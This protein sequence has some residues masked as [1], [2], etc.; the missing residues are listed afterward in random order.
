MSM[1]P[2]PSR[3][4]PADTAR[5]AH[6]IFH[7]GNPYLDL[8]DALG[9]LFDDA[10]FADLYAHQGAPA[11]APSCLA[12]V[13][14]LQYVEGLS[15]RQTANAVRARIDWKYLLGLSLEDDGFDASDLS[16]FRTR[17]LAGGAETTLFTQVLERCRDQGLLK[18]ERQRTDSTHVLGAIR[19]LNRLELVGETMRATLDVLAV[20]APEWLRENAA[21]EWVE[22]Y[23]PRVEEYRLPKGQAARERLATMIGA[24]GVAL[25]AAIDAAEQTWLRTIPAVGVLRQVWEQ[26]YRREGEDLVW[27]RAGQMPPSAAVICS[28]YDPDVRYSKK[29]Q[30]TWEGYKVHLTETCAADAPILITQV[31][32]TLA[33]V[34]D[35]QMTSSIQED[36]A[37]R[38]LTPALHVVDAGYINGQGLAQSQDRGI[39]LCGPVAPD[40]S[41]QARA[42]AGFALADFG[43]DWDA[44]VATC[45]QG[46]HS[47]TWRSVTDRSGA[48][49]VQVHFRI[50]DCQACPVR[51]LCTTGA[52]RSLTFRPQPAHDARQHALARQTTAA[53]AEEYTVRAGIESTFVQGN[54]RS[55]L[56]HARYRGLPKVRL[57]HRLTAAA[58]NLARV[59]AWLHAAPR[60]PT[61]RST[62]VRLMEPAA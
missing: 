57:Q 11:L 10:T 6:K 36:L 52:R 46:K 1:R 48:A 15:D 33:T 25:L 32:T 34:T 31:D 38:N 42:G 29:R 19:T 5:V 58:L 2:R 49:C 37:A 54:R 13:S 60:A 27:R 26:Q 53:F 24:D 3:P 59:A 51:T 40:A 23:G 22:R 45:P 39:D 16:D 8:R 47:S 17:V 41:W 7:R 18:A 43:L 56:R 20:V 30:T 62:F 55:D 14:I 4:V 12:L 61:R 44:E 50:T 28:P 21:P 35:E 9:P